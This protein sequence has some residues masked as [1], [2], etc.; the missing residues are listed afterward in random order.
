MKTLIAYFSR[1][2]ENIEDG[3]IVELTKGNTEKVAEK[4]H[5]LIEGSDLY[6]I[7][8]EEPYPHTYMD[9]NFRAK[10]EI[11][12]NERPALKDTIGLN[13]ANYD[14]IY[15]GFPIWYR[16]YPRIVATFL[17]KYDLTGKRVIPFCT[18][19]EGYFGLSI[20]ELEKHIPGA[21]IKKGLVIRGCEVDGSDDKIREFV[22]NNK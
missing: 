2:G 13:M 14:T 4:M 11:E 7:E 10:R 19:D 18:N 9:C 20:L 12:N 8:E 5:S 17:E 21:D 1:I 22:E 16:T 3:E 6:K 15:I